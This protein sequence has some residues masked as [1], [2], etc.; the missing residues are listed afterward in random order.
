MPPR[1]AAIHPLCAIEGG[2][3]TIEGSD[4]PIDPAAS[5]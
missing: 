5:A 1:V 2:R 3:I 4:F